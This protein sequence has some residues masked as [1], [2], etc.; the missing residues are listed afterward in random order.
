MMRKERYFP[1]FRRNSKTIPVHH[2]LP[3]TGHPVCFKE[4]ASKALT[5]TSL[6]CVWVD[7]NRHNGQCNY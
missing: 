4:F 5:T 6:L 7:Q 2:R 1:P 3:L